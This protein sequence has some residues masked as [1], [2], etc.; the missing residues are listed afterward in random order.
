[1]IKIGVGLWYGKG[2]FFKTHIQFCY[3]LLAVVNC[4]G[5]AV[6]VYKLRPDVPRET[7]RI[8]NE[9]P[10]TALQNDPKMPAINFFIPAFTSIV[11][12][13]KKLKLLLLLYFTDF[14]T[15]YLT[16]ISISQLYI[17]KYEPIYSKTHPSPSP[18]PHPTHLTFYD[19]EASLGS[20]G[21]FYFFCF[22]LLKYLIN[23]NLLI[24][25]NN[26]LLILIASFF[27]TGNSFI[28]G[29][30][31]YDSISLHQLSVIWGTC[32]LTNTLI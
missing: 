5:L 14:G 10:E 31:Y 4:L 28:I 30:I 15:H 19:Y 16:L 18:S 11:S 7:P 12:Q 24:I 23:P 22:A 13:P 25:K 27:F 2:G 32:G 6:I 1:M 3:L 20:L 26:T 17:D 21:V 29:S 9:N 8:P